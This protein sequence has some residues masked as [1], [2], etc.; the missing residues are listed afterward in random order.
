ME[1]PV[2][3]DVSLFFEAE[4]ESV[5]RAL[6]QLMVQL[7]LHGLGPDLLGS[8]EIVV[9]EALNNIVEHAHATCQGVISLR[10]RTVAQQVQFELLDQGLPMPGGELPK[11]LAAVVDVVVDD[12]PEG[13]FGWF[14]IRS[15]SQDLRYSRDGDTN[16]LSFSMPL[17][18]H[19]ISA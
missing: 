5:R 15:L 11:G 7:Q 8:I 4:P 9:A 18:P 12:L 3:V 14:L 17:Q 6:H 13:G 19:S 16:R 1:H 2:P 10:A